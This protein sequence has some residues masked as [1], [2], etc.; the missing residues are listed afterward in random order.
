MAER[1]LRDDARE[2]EHGEA[3]VREL[4]ELDKN[5]LAAILFDEMGL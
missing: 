3:A 2:G 4:G 1:A 5:D